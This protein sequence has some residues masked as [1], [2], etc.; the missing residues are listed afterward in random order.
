MLN[1]DKGD[2]KIINDILDHIKLAGFENS[3]T[4]FS[5]SNTSSS[6]GDLGW[7]NSSSL[8]SNI[9]EIISNLKVGQVS[10]PIIRQ[11]SVLFLKLIDK[12]IADTKDKDFEILKKNIINQKKNELFNL[13]SSSHLSK[14]KNSTYIEYKQ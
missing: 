13:Y 12:R 4:K 9:F 2:K 3:V 5:I 1:N 7:I 8:S 14:L 10:K 6:K 11:N